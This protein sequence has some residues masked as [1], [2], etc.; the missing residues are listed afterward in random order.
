MKMKA[1]YS[2]CEKRGIIEQ[3]IFPAAAGNIFI[4]LMRPM[5]RRLVFS[6]V[7]ALIPLIIG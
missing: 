6:T 3:K 4:I 5:N 1:E 2:A 7:F